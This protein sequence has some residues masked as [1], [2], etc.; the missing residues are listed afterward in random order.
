MKYGEFSSHTSQA[1]VYYARQ[2]GDIPLV[3]VRK[4]KN[5]CQ[6]D[7]RVSGTMPK[8]DINSGDDENR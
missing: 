3:G 7:F 5:R 1:I 6:T 8:F 2:Q 4:P